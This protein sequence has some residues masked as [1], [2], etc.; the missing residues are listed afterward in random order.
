MRLSL[1]LLSA[2]P[3]AAYADCTGLHYIVCI[4]HYSTLRGVTKVRGAWWC[5][6]RGAASLYL[7]RLCKK[8]IRRGLA[9][10]SPSWSACYLRRLTRSETPRGPKRL[11]LLGRKISVRHLLPNST[12]LPT[13]AAQEGRGRREVEGHGGEQQQHQQHQQQQSHSQP[14]PTHREHHRHPR[15]K[16]GMRGY[17]THIVS[18]V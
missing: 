3:G 8:A 7:G 15:G 18:Q 2:T 13:Q 9:V 17:T 1:Q 16:G 12:G 11:R 6:V 10:R 5:E 4:L 14:W